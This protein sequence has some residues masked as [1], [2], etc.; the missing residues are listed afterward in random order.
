[1]VHHFKKNLEFNLYLCFEN[2]PAKDK[3]FT[4]KYATRLFIPPHFPACT[5][6]RGLK[7]ALAP[8]VIVSP[9]LS[10][11]LQIPPTRCFTY[12]QVPLP[13]R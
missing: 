10:K 11:A 3:H 8:A 4:F 1:M 2:P 9:E 7:L 12:I 13:S 5:S 6:E